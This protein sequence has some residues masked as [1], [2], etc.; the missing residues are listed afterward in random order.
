MEAAVAYMQ[1]LFQD[2]LE[3]TMET[4]ENPLVSTAMVCIVTSC[5]LVPY[6]T[7]WKSQTEGR[8]SFNVTVETKVKMDWTLNA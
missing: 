3:P 5:S 7:I 4:Q 1:A 8:S 2:L 6:S